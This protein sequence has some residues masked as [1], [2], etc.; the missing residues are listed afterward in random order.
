ME[1]DVFENEEL[2]QRAD[3]VT[4]YEEAIPVVKEY[5]TIIRSQKKKHFKYHI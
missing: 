5:E 2:A 1:S 4:N 3:N